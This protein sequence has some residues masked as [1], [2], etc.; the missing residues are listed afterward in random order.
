M[1]EGN[2][3]SNYLLKYTCE[4]CAGAKCE[5]V[6]DLP[7][8]PMNCL[9]GGGTKKWTYSQLSTS[10]DVP[11]DKLKE[12]IGIIRHLY[13]FAPDSMHEDRPM[14]MTKIEDF[15]SS[16]ED[17]K[18]YMDAGTQGTDPLYTKPRRRIVGRIEGPGR[19]PTCRSDQKNHYYFDDGT[20]AGC[21]ILGG[22]DPWH[23]KEESK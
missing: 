10:D 15:L 21:R 12:A 11:A 9:Y 3:M 4:G 1:N 2:E 20:R 19:C 16:L 22:H 17:G 13:A 18:D 7:D 14:L 23:D 6:G 5:I 8:P